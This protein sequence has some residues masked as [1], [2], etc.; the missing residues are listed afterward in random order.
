MKRAFL[1]NECDRGQPPA[2]P[3]Q[4]R[5]TGSEP[6]EDWFWLEADA[7]DVLN[8]LLDVLFQ[9]DHVGRGGLVAIYD[10]QRVLAR[11]ADASAAVASGESGMFDQPGG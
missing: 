4:H 10:C 2:T 8:P 9:G 11:D 5:T 6:Y 7:P 3:E 1:Q